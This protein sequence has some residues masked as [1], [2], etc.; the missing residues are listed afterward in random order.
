MLE[1]ALDTD[2]LVQG[3][4]GK[5]VAELFDAESGEL[6]Q[7]EET[8]NF[9]SKPALDFL[10]QSQRTQ[11][12][13]GIY[14]LN[15]S[16][17][18]DDYLLD[19]SDAVLVLTDLAAATD[20]ATE[21]HMYGQFT[22][23]ANK[24]N[25]SGSDA[26]RGTPNGALCTATESQVQWVFDWPTNAANGTINSLGWVKPAGF[27]TT[28]DAPSVYYPSW[29]SI[30][31]SD[32]SPQTWQYFS[33]ASA[34]LSFG[35]ISSNLTVRVLNGSFAQTNSF[36]VSTQFTVISGIAWDGVNSKLWVIGTSGGVAKIASYTSSGALIDAPITVA[37]RTYTAL[38]FDGSKLWSTTGGGGDRRG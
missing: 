16:L 35:T 3:I 21:T 38:A 24:S 28:G 30:T 33:R 25:Y 36:S 32:T 7:R 13:R 34:S 4:E 5:V 19:K 37:N 12:S 22:G 14:P 23:W 18:N 31:A 10:K 9:I 6:V 2:Q 29:S 15:N 20:P 17:N 1:E 11:F 8:H 27:Y 26:Y